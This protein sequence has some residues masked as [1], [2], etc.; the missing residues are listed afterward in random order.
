MELLSKEHRFFHTWSACYL[1]N[2]VCLNLSPPRRLIRFSFLLCFLFFF[3]CNF[4]SFF[5]GANSGRLGD[6][7]DGLLGAVNL[8]IMLPL[9]ALTSYPGKSTTNSYSCQKSHKQF[10]FQS[11]KHFVLSELIQQKSNFLLRDTGT[12]LELPDCNPNKQSYTFFTKC[13]TRTCILGISECSLI[14]IQR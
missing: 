9:V 11:H 6:G 3:K 13:S 4:L 2:L 7:S 8:R 5:L 12:K 10:L 1:G 14:P